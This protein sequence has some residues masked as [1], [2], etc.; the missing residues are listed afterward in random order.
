MT[1]ADPVNAPPIRITAPA[2]VN[3]ILRVLDRRPDGFHDIWSIMQTV[4][5]HDDLRVSA[6]DRPGITLTSSDP[7][8]PIDDRNLVVRAAKA[9]LTRAGAERAI[10]I[11]LTK[12]IPMGG[13]LGGGSSDAAATLVLL[14]AYLKL[15]WTL[16]T[17]AEISAELGSDVAF[18]LY[19]PTA[20]VTGR[21]ER[22]SA[23]RM[24]GQR[25]VVLVNPGF[26][27]ETRWA[28]AELA[29][30][31]SSVTPVDPALLG[32]LG[33]EPLP[34]ERLLPYMRN[35]FEAALADAHPVFAELGGDL[36]RRGAEAAM[37]SGSGATVFGIFRDEG[38]ARQA[39]S[40]V[41]VERRLWTAA[42]PA[43]GTLALG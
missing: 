27:V 2:K 26:Q 9:V 3:L 15:G 4:G 30:R 34:W 6:G 22:V 20:L 11:D 35:D 19:A 17:L 18:F 31:R 5:L 32:L 16:E 33:I 41:A 25:W 14:N 7:L 24:S 40:A 10:R 28:Y 36:R 13:G 43:A 12:R 1:P 37:L 39:A 38:G 29:A 21:G 23:M 8:L 42:V